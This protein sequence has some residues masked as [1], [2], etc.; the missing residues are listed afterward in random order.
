MFLCTLPSPGAPAASEESL[1]PVPIW[2]LKP[3]R[4]EWR[5][6][7]EVTDTAC[8]WSLRCSQQ[9]GRG[10]GVRGPN[11][12]VAGGGSKAQESLPWQG[13]RGRPQPARQDHLLS[14]APA[15]PSGPEEVWGEGRFPGPQLAAAGSWQ[16]WPASTSLFSILYQVGGSQALPGSVFS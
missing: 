5:K 7:H 14:P 12:E 10:T 11:R 9:T 16:F 15:I 6:S 13:A 4:W 8:H 2:A 3:G 1:G